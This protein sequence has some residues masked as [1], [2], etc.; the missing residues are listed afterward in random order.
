ME[1][2]DKIKRIY[3]YYRPIFLVL[4][5]FII[6]LIFFI[7]PV[8]GLFILAFDKPVAGV[9]DIQAQWTFKSFVRIYSRSLYFDAVVT[10]VSLASLVS[11]IALIIG[12]PLAYLIAKTEH[13]GRN[14]F[15]MIFKIVWGVI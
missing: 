4:P 12:Y 8:T 6:F 2:S 13:V 15:L 10:S 5:A 9:I 11:F 1:L 14:T 3:I 7:I